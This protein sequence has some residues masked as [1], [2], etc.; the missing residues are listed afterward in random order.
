MTKVSARLGDRKQIASVS[1]CILHPHRMHKA[2]TCDVD[3]DI[4]EDTGFSLPRPCRRFGH[5]ERIVPYQTAEVRIRPYGTS[6]LYKNSEY[7]IR[8]QLQAYTQHTGYASET[9]MYIIDEDYG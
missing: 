2:Y 1:L 3:E 4:V 8:P 9:A 6:T 5:Y 7:F